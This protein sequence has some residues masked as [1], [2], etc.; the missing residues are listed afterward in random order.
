MWIFII[1]I[2]AIITVVVINSLDSKNTGSKDVLKENEVTG[3][4]TQQISIE[5]KPK[6]TITTS[7][8]EYKVIRKK[9]FGSYRLN[10]RPD[11]LNKE[12]LVK[13]SSMRGVEFKVNPF[14]LTC[15]CPDFQKRRSDKDEDDIQRVCKHL[16]KILKSTYNNVMD[17]PDPLVLKLY[18]EYR[19]KDFYEKTILTERIIIGHQWDETTVYVVIRNRNNRFSIYPYSISHKFWQETKP[20]FQNILADL[21]NDLFEYKIVSEQP[22]N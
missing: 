11:E 15:T 7:S 3:N 17:L 10:P 1:I 18:S 9:E 6:L 8:V 20:V 4:D 12:Y 2:L 19:I 22:L 16:Y 13:S 5:I 14:E 21:F